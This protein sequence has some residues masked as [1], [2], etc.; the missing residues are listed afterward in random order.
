MSLL[1]G[2]GDEAFL[3]LLAVHPFAFVLFCLR[4]GSA[5]AKQKLIPQNSH[6]FQRLHRDGIPFRL[7]FT[8][9]LPKS[10]EL[11]KAILTTI[12]PTIK[13]RQA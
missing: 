13:S 11:A 5:T 7:R 1:Y 9:A 6:S 3:G 4:S 12:I 2:A 10:A 8:S